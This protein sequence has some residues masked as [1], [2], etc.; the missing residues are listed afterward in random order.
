MVS[1]ISLLLGL[2]YGYAIP[3][4][5]TASAVMLGSVTLGAFFFWVEGQSER[6]VLVLLTSLIGRYCWA[7]FA[8]GTVAGAFVQVFLR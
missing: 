4:L 6:R 5:W 2:W 3:P 8:F 1:S 7:P